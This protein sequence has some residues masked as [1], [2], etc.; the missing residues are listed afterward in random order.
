[1]AEMTGFLRWIDDWLAARPGMIPVPLL[2]DTLLIYLGL[3]WLGRQALPLFV[4][5]TFADTWGDDHR[6]HETLADVIYRVLLEQGACSLATMRQRFAEQLR[7]V[8]DVVSV[9]FMHA[10]R[11]QLAALDG[12]GPPAFIESGVQGTFILPLLALSDPAAGMLLYTTVPWLYDTY[13]PIVYQ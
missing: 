6:I 9:P 13:A 1:M 7:D 11:Q 2:R 12:G 3:T 8:P 10:C 5:R 4:S